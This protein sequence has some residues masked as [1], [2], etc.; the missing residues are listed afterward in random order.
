[1]SRPNVLLTGN[2]A[3][4]RRTVVGVLSIAARIGL[5]NE[6][7]RRILV[8][9]GLPEIVLDEPEVPITGEHGLAITRKLLLR[10]DPARSVYGHAVFNGLDLQATDLGLLGLALLYS[11]SALE[12]MKVALTYPE[13]SWGY[14]RIALTL[15]EHAT[16][17]SFAVDVRVPGATPSEATLV[18]DYCMT[19]DLAATIGLYANVLGPGHEPQE[20]WLPYPAPHD[21]DTIEQRLPCPVRFDA[22]EGRLILDRN[23][24]EATPRQANPVAFAMHTRQ[25]EQIARQLRA[26]KDLSEQVRRLLWTTPPANR[27]E[28]AM[29]LAMSPRTL[30]RKLA[31]EGTSFATLLQKV[32]QERARQYLRSDDRSLSEIAALLGFSDAT[33]FSRAFRGWEGQS[34]STWRRQLSSS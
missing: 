17:A 18:R 11:S 12:A 26:D 28:V 5:P 1:M 21:A 8:D 34:P 32:R 4:P 10:L 13:L 23:F 27:N 33:A 9:S 15:E 16:I 25:L 30:A 22:P 2:L 29:M 31:T 24:I 19:A 3:A 6:Q 7:T 14:S 20:V